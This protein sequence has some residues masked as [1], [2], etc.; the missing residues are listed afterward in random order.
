VNKKEVAQR[1]PL[2]LAFV[3]DG[4]WTIYVR[5]AV[6]E[7]VNTKVNALHRAT[8]AFVNAAA[9][10]K[11]Y[12]ELEKMLTEDELDIANRARNAHHNTTPKNAT[13]ADYKRSTALEAV[14]GYIYLQEDE[15]RTKQLCDHAYSFYKK[16]L[17]E[18][19]K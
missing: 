6:V 11:I 4:V 18:N 2:A 5:R 15:A 19:S 8:S 9:Q 13:L 12:G 17:E 10:S 7:C 1:N 16:Y 3:G 14:L